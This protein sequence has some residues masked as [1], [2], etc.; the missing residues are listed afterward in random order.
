MNELLLPFAVALGIGLL[1]GAERER[2]KGSGPARSPAG[3]RTFTVV[4][5][6]GAAAFSVGGALLLA[7][8]AAGIAALLAVAYW[9]S[10]DEDPGLTTEVALLVTLFLGALAIRE[11]VVASALAVCV[12]I[13]LAARSPLHRFTRRLLTAA[14]M[15]DA[16]ILC[17]SALVVLPLLPDRDL[18]P[19]D[20]LNPRSLWMVVV[21]VMAI[22]AAGHIAT[23]ALGARHG[24]PLTGLMSGFVSSTATI[25]A[26]GARAKADPAMLRPAVAAAVLSTVA[27]ILQMTAVLAAVS[28]STLSAM[29]VPLLCAGVVA[30]VYGAV[31]TRYGLRDAA[32]PVRP[33]Q[34]RAF[35]V[36]SAVLFAAFVGAML[37]VS[38]AI[39]HW[40]GQRGVIVAAALA[41]FADTHA[42]AISVASLVRAGTIAA[43][44]AVYPI[45]AGLTTNTVSKIVFAYVNGGMPF[46]LRVVPGLVLVI[47]GAWAGAVLGG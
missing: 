3:I 33:Q 30:A 26:M 42:P 44:D 7:V 37:L 6:A 20:A 24:L 9:R 25:G 22:G 40:A 39:Q 46:A 45:L 16:L 19:F 21:L 28:P 15:T 14:E 5:L 23:R 43:G 13:L 18:G 38:A 12:A 2:R 17:A 10:T 31:F 29:W 8:L 27:T 32:P 35:S 36:R 1:I 34:T 41:G 11:P 47:A 4:S